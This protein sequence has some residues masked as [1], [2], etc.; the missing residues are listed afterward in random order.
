MPIQLDGQKAAARVVID[1]P[2]DEAQTLCGDLTGV[3]I[4][5][6]RMHTLTHQAAEGLT[7]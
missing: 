5:S 7:V 2:Y 6:E 4:G 3:S 1:M